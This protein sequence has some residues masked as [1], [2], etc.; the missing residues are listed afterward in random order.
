MNNRVN[1]YVDD[2]V[3]Y[4]KETFDLSFRGNGISY[5]SISVC[6]VDCVYSLRAKYESVTVP[7]IDRY[8]ETYMQNNK[9]RSGDNVSDLLHH[10]NEAGGPESF[11]HNILKNN[12][13][14]GGVLKSAVCYK[15]AYFLKLLGIETI[16]DFRSYESMELLETV[17]RSVNGIGDAAANYLFM[18]AGDSGRCKPDVHIRRCVREAC[19][20]SLSD[21]EYQDL[22]KSAIKILNKDYPSLTVSSLDYIIWEYYQKR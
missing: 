19:N 22:F 21:S 15:L 8:A 17:V 10:I 14:S 11:A 5:E 9:Y 13:L 20:T 16:E 7:V 2:F 18:L 6:I 12:Q 1:N 4:C 3:T